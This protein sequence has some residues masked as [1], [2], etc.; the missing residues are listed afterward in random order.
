MEK[1]QNKIKYATAISY[2]SDGSVDKTHVNNI[3]TCEI[4]RYSLKRIDYMCRS[5]RT[6]VMWSSW[7]I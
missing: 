6:F 2:W 5:R 7:D 3:Y 1:L 4:N